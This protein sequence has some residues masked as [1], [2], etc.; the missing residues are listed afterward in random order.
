MKILLHACCAPCAIYPVEALRSEGAD[1]MG[2]FYRHNIHPFTE[3][4]KRENTLR[5]Y[6][7]S[8][9]M[10]VIWSQGYDLETFIR[11]VAW[12]ED[13]RCLYCYHDRLTKTAEIAKHGKFDCFST[14]LLYSIYQQ[15]DVIRSMG[16]SVARSTGIDFYYKDFRIGWE[17]GVNTS[18]S[19][20]LYRQAYCGCIYSEKERYFKKQRLK[21][22]G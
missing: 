5:K 12:R 21:I 1:V 20:E 15:H 13:Q 3:C 9:G 14:T 22:E 7:E 4:I 2:Y 18:R 10:D 17:Y 19:L 6:S 11:N 16:E 8:I